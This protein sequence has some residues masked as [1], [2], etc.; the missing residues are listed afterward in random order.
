VGIDVV[1]ENGTSLGKVADVLETGAND[2][3][4]VRDEASELL[5]PAIDSV[6]KEIDT[7]ASRMVVEL[8]PGLERRALKRPTGD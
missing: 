8:I 7:E 2:V 4:I 6:I 3:Y 5:I 1:D